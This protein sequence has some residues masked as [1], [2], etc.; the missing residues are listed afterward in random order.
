MSLFQNYKNI[1][2]PNHIRIYKEKLDDKEEYYKVLLEVEKC[3][4]GT[5]SG[6]SESVFEWKNGI[7]SERDKPKIY[8]KFYEK[9]CD[10]TFLQRTTLT[11]R[12]Y[13]DDIIVGWKIISRWD[14]GTNG[15]WDLK[16]NPLLKKNIECDFISK[17][18]RGQH[19]DAY[20]YLIEKPK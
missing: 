2:I 17:R 10:G 15:E 13:Y 16:S 12:E 4:S 8:K 7:C 5:L 20:V 3:G 19:F 14:D 9:K 18:F 11:L 6:D 1:Y